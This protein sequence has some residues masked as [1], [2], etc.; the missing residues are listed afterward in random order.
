MLRTGDQVGPYTLISRLGK[1]GFGVV[2]L[3]ERRTRITTT[4]VALK[5]PLDS[6]VDLDAIK[7][8]ADL[9]VQASG[10]PNVLPIIEAND[11]DDYIIIA[12]EYAPDGS[13]EYWLRQHDGQAP[14]LES[15]IEMMDGILA[16]L[17]HL[18][19][20]NIIHRD[21][22][23]DNIL[24]QGQTPRLTDFG[25]SRVLKTTSHSLVIAGTPL[26]MAP[27]AFAGIRNVRTDIW[28]MGVI[29]YQLLASHLPF[30]G[31]DLPSIMDAVRTTYPPPLSESIPYSIREIIDC[32]LH[33][34]P[35]KR[36]NSSYEMRIAIKQAFN[37]IQKQPDMPISKKL[38]D[39]SSPIGNLTTV[40]VQNDSTVLSTPAYQPPS[41]EILEDLVNQRMTT[42]LKVKQAFN[43][44]VAS[45]VLC[46][47][48]FI[49]IPLA[50]IAIVRATKALRI[51]RE[52]DLGQE[53]ERKAKTATAIAVFTLSITG[54]FLILWAFKLI[55]PSQP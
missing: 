35:A 45:L 25:I 49:S 43:F 8:E 16:G 11:Y 10:H 47:F 32:A 40:S 38:S 52:N 30:L 28:S 27:E 54:L 24:L 22:K 34:D 55:G 18:H 44:A 13:L 4:K 7:R 1:G 42:T 5:I 37:A 31:S 3:A 19:S 15:A 14:S 46:L 33:K 2:W 17:E 36:F 26:Y 12:S 39:E 20:R 9:W 6:E 53:Y 41:N 51:I 50:V 23:P 21:L 48:W 29:F